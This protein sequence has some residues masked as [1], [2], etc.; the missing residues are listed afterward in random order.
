MPGAS[1]PLQKTPMRIGKTPCWKQVCQQT[2][3]FNQPGAFVL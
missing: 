2:Y 1:P 3:H